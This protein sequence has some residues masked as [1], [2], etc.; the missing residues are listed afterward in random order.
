MQPS[1]TITT[2]SFTTCG[3]QHRHPV[4]SAND[5][6]TAAATV[7]PLHRQT[8]CPPGTSDGRRSNP[9]PVSPVLDR[10][11]S[12]HTPPRE[13]PEYCTPQ[14]G[15]RLDAT[16]QVLRIGDEVSFLAMQYTAGG[17]ATIRRF[18]ATF[19]I[20]RHGNGGEVRCAPSNVTRLLP[21]CC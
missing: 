19:I 11:T 14:A 13:P 12:H 8:P 18:T 3:T 21:P 10:H 17:T 9:L 15:D 16:G 5:T 2:G 1:N 6:L 20:L 4:N 7:R